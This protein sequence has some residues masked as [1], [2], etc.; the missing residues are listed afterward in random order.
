MSMSVCLHVCMLECLY[1]RM[2][3][4]VY[5]RTCVCMSCVLG[6]W[7]ALWN[8]INT[9]THTIAYAQ[10]HTKQSLYTHTKTF[11]VRTSHANTLCADFDLHRKHATSCGN[12]SWWNDCSRPYVG[13]RKL[14]KH[15][16]TLT[17]HYLWF[18]QPG[19]RHFRA[20]DDNGW[21]GGYLC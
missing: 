19:P 20:R 18:D 8:T 10:R 5:L 3:V 4:Y 9:Y 21:R 6:A 1:V 11:C 12:L 7:Y 13:E 14:H 2:C 17:S 15:S 16:F